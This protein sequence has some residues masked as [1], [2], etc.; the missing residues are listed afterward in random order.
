[1]TAGILFARYFS[2]MSPISVLSNQF[3]F[4]QDIGSRFIKEGIIDC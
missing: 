2:V 4:E 1:M 3:L